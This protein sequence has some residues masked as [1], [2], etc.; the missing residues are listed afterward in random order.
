[1]KFSHQ[2]KCY[3]V[4]YDPK[5]ETPDSRMARDEMAPKKIVRQ[6]EVGPYPKLEL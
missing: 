5:L 6:I 1:M 4:L 2:E 3:G